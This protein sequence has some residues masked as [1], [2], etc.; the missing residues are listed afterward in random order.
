MDQ[1]DKTTLRHF[2]VTAIPFVA[3]FSLILVL[4]YMVAVPLASPLAWAALFSFFMHPLYS[5]LSERLFRGRFRNIAAAL[6]T[7][8]IL[9]LI[10]IPGVFAGTMLAR[11]VLRNYGR[12]LDLM[13]EFS[14]SLDVADLKAFLPQWLASRIGPLGDY[15]DFLRDNLQQAGGWTASRLAALSRAFAQNVFGL[16]WQ[17]VVITVA[18]FFMTRDGHLIVEYIEAVLPLSEEERLAVMNRARKLLRAVVYGITFTAAIQ[19]VLGA[20]G[21]AFA[22]LPTPMLFGIL[23][24]LFAMIPFVGTPLVLV[25]GSL[26]LLA[27]GETRTGL[28]LLVWSLGVV[29]TVD[30]F[31]RPLFISEGSGA[32]ILIVF[33][34]VIGGLAAWGF[35][36]IFLGPLVISLF[37]FFLDSYRR[38]LEIQR[39][40]EAERPAAA[41]K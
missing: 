30:N 3:I 35:L 1:Q 14:G 18:S 26:Y 24:F 31:I 36:G 41:R 13:V 34:G 8:A 39:R 15:V 17:L 28:L 2:K 7:G 12:I 5:L 32:H 40:Q 22:G 19:A 4:S 21:W 6:V 11:E 29:S 9:L 25:P 20:T 38:I 23:M 27:T 37:V 10:V 16:V 33:I